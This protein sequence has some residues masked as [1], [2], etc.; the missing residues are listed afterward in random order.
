MIQYHEILYKIILDIPSGK[1]YKSFYFCN[2]H[3]TVHLQLHILYYQSNILSCNIS[4]YNHYICCYKNSFSCCNKKHFSNVKFFAGFPRAQISVDHK[5]IH[6]GSEI[7]IMSIDISNPPADKF[8]WQKSKDGKVF[9][10]ID[11]T[12]P[13][14]FGSN[15]TSKHPILVIP[16]ATFEDKLYYR[17]VLWNKFGEDVSNTVDINITGSMT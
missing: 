4:N 12:K 1:K 7:K 13:K 14:Y 5:D 10:S 17:L 8:E 2:L 11:I 9:A 15:R 16:K 6:V 3:R